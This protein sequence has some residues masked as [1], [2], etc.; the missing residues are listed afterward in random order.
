MC[1]GDLGKVA[2]GHYH[3]RFII[4]VGLDI[5]LTYPI[6]CFAIKRGAIL[7]GKVSNKRLA[8]LDE[9]MRRVGE[10]KFQ[11]S[12][13]LNIIELTIRETFRPPSIVY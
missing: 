11:L 7:A 1:N 2:R 4:G 3:V 5:G 8:S 10:I 13:E 9:V 12:D 6:Y